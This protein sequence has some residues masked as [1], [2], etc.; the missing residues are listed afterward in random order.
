MPESHQQN[1]QR[2]ELAK[3]RNQRA[4][5][6]A[7]ATVLA[8]QQAQRLEPLVRSTR[9]SYLRAPMPLQAVVD[10]LGGDIHKVDPT[11]QWLALCAHEAW[12]CG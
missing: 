12:C 9:A 2:Q 10:L 4:A 8:M 3:I 6:T 1:V 7:A 5:T 11:E